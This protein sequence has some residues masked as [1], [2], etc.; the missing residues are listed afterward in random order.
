[1]YQDLFRPRALRGDA[2]SSSCSRRLCKRVFA[3]CEVCSAANDVERVRDATNSAIALST[4]LS[5]GD[6]EVRKLNQEAL[7]VESGMGAKPPDK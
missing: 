5:A 1:V 4:A 3:S 6:S 7:Q 2:L